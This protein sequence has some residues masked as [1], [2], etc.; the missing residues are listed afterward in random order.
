MRGIRL[1]R[2]HTEKATEMT[3]DNTT[4]YRNARDLLV[5]YHGDYERAHR[6]FAWPAIEGPFN[7]A[8]DWFDV[9]ADGNTRRA[10]LILDEDGTERRGLS[11]RS[12]AAPTR[13]RAGWR[14]SGRG[15]AMP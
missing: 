6:E 2:L 14:I 11:T 10:L 15:R 4:A 9:V 7:W 3:N 12:V 13:S 1:A 5:R 8:I